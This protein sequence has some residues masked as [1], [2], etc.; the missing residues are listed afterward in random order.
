[1]SEYFNARHRLEELADE[2]YKEFQAKITPTAKPILGVRV[3]LMRTLAKEILHYDWRSW[4]VNSP[5]DY[6]EEISLKGFVIGYAKISIIERIELTTWFLPYIDNWATCDSFVATL[7]FKN[8]EKDS[9]WHFIEP[10]MFSDYEFTARFAI[11]AALSLFNDEAYLPTITSSFDHI[12][13][14]GYYVKMAVAWAISALAVDNPDDIER[15]LKHNNL[16]IFTHNKAIQK[17]CESFR[18]P[19]NKKTIWKTLKR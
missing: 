12:S 10:L 19:S 18:I 15:Y 9:F 11:V 14:E 13:H 6:F 4:L 3:P 2:N 1:M 8:E 17:C 16:D 5:N 7:R